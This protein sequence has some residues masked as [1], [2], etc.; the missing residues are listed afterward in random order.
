MQGIDS[1]WHDMLSLVWGLCSTCSNSHWQHTTGHVPHRQLPG[2]GRGSCLRPPLISAV[3][4]PPGQH[5]K[6]RQTVHD[7]LHTISLPAQSQQKCTCSC[8]VQFIADDTS[9]KCATLVDEQTQDGIYAGDLLLPY[10]PNTSCIHDHVCAN[11][12]HTLSAGDAA[13]QGWEA[14]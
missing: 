7:G 14:C 2:C 6:V 1:Q 5:C 4:Q 3:C 11:T 9:L 13:R 8:P 10:T 12:G